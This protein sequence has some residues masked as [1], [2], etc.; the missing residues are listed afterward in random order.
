VHRGVGRLFDRE[1][2]LLIVG[3]GIHGAAV[4]WDAA[5]RGL[6]VALVE[7]NDFASG[8]SWNSLKTI[9][10][11]LRH[12]Q[13]ADL[14]GLRESVRERRALLRIAPGLVRPLPFVVPAYGH[15]P[16]G[17]EA[18]ALAVRLYDLLSADRNDGLR[19]NRWLR[20]SRVLSRAE[21][22]ESVPGLPQ[23]GLAG[24]VEWTDAQVESSERLVLAFLHAAASAGAVLANHVEAL[25]LEREAGRVVGARLRDA[26]TGEQASARARLV[27]NAAGPGLEPLLERSGLPSRRVP[28]LA[29]WNLVLRR[30]MAFRHAVGASSGAR[31]L[32]LVPWRDHCMVGTGYAPAA[33][34]EAGLGAFPAEAARA[35]PWAGIET[36]DVSLVHRGL[37][38]GR[39]PNALWT[40]S[41]LVD[42][43]SRDGVPGLVSLVGAKYTTARRLAE[44]AVD[45]AFRRLGRSVPPCGTAVTELPV[46]GHLGGT[47][48]EQTLRAVREEMA[49]S[50]ADVVLR[51]L[52]LGTAGRPD[53]ASLDAVATSMAE[54]LGWGPERVAEEKRAFEGVWHG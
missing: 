25:A 21:A 52:D 37:V 11:G 41:R 46:A 27:L 6:S 30:P 4:A 19:E 23:D 43:E 42:H 32:F 33:E 18:L 48:A 44:S 8:T 26:E 39:G 53:A 1:H 36:A 17:F 34:A 12:L 29:A 15:G 22:L 47:L 38:P 16:K 7:A 35:F 49:R 3:G 2:D 54:E 45:L 13:R 51:R 10:G 20:G 50:L 31:F 40:R 24:A 14:A 5:Q 28:L 9:H